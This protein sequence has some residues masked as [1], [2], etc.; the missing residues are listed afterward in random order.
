MAG[1]KTV[2]DAQREY[3]QRRTERYHRMQAALVAIMCEVEDRDSPV[4]LR[5][6]AMVEK[7]LR[8]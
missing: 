2:A 6:K 3:R 4:A 8:K 7:G 1:S 5:I